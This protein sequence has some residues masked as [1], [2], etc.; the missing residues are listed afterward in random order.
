M[1][2]ELRAVSRIQGVDQSTPSWM[3]GPSSEAEDKDDEI[4]EEERTW[5]DPSAHKL[6]SAVGKWMKEDH[7]RQ[8]I[9]RVSFDEQEM[10][11]SM[12]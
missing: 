11:L 7:R 12:T 2:G 9:I 5:R 1:F 3:V 8:E 10:T 6:R 4:D